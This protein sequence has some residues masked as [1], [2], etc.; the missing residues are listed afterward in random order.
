MTDCPH[1]GSR[2]SVDED[3]FCNAGCGGQNGPRVTPPPTPVENLAYIL[4]RNTAANVIPK[5]P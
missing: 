4:A 3:F 2:L 5:K 1:C